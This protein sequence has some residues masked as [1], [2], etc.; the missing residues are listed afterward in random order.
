MATFTQDKQHGP[1]ARTTHYV[2]RICYEV[3]RGDLYPHGRRFD[4][5]IQ[6]QPG[7]PEAFTY[8]KPRDDSEAEMKEAILRLLGIG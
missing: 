4:L 8:I 7:A 2:D 6:K 3:V 1:L 5:R